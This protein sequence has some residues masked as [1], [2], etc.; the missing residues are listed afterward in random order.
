MIVLED[1]RINNFDDSYK[2]I[3]LIL[4]N[5]IHIVYGTVGFKKL[6]NIK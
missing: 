6:L 5:V 4:V 3:I 2:I 1:S